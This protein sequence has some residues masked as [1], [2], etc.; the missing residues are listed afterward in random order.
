LW[1]SNAVTLAPRAF[2]HLPLVLASPSVATVDIR[3]STTGLLLTLLAEAGEGGPVLPPVPLPCVLADAPAETIELAVPGSGVYALELRNTNFLSLVAFSAKVEHEPV[4]ERHRVAM[5][6]ELSARR[7]ELERVA[8]QEAELLQS[9]EALAR[10]LWEVQET[11]RRHQ[12][13]QQ[14]L[15]EE[16]ASVELA[17]A[18]PEQRISAE[19]RQPKPRGSMEEKGSSK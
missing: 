6:Q 5:L 8:Q 19:Y 14:Q 18:K 16:V 9:E 3:P 17:L 13:I 15:S 12:V 4:A 7:L 1:S 2:I 10:R 11:R